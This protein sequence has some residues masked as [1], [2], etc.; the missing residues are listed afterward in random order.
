LLSKIENILCWQGGLVE[1]KWAVAC[2]VA[3][4]MTICGFG[5]SHMV[6]TSHAE[7]LSRVEA[8]GEGSS[9]SATPTISLPA[10]PTNGI[11]EPEDYSGGPRYRIGPED[12]LRISVWENPELSLDVVVRPDGMISVPLLQDVKA[13]GM[14][15]GEVAAVIQRNLLAYIKDPSVS[16]IVLQVNASK[17]FV[18]GYVK[19]PGVFPLRGDVSVLQAISLAGGFTDFASPRKIRLVRNAGHRQEVRVVN[20][21][22]IID[23][24]GQGNYLL[25]PGDTIVVP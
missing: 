18:I 5:G 4:F 12:V 9:G 1:A 20:Y 15:A 10:A 17:F 22:D 2:A 3:V 23:R 7:E 8:G 19:T 6:S 14:T 21:Y 24:G 16:V 25:K 11:A 13:E